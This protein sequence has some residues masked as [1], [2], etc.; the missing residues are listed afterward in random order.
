MV[1]PDELNLSPFSPGSSS[2]S[3]RATAALEP[4]GPPSLKAMA[5][6]GGVPVEER[7]VCVT[8][9]KVQGDLADLT[10]TLRQ[11]TNTLR[12]KCVVTGNSSL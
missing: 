7:E 10:N 3:P 4:F 2:G 12:K 5:W 11:I 6:E 8:G 9:T 1:S